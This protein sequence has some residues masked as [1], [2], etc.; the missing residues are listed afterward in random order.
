M[1]QPIATKQQFREYLF[2]V[3]RR[4]ICFEDYLEMKRSCK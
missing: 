3:Y 2:S 4:F 1:H